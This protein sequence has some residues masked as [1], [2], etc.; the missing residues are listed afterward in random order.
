MSDGSVLSVDSDKS[1]LKSFASIKSD[2][3]SSKTKDKMDSE[4]RTFYLQKSLPG[5]IILLEIGLIEPFFYCKIHAL[6]AHRI[7]Q[8]ASSRRSTTLQ[9]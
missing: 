1:S 4:D 9:V 8:N 2:S 7:Q 5:G 6:E 3:N